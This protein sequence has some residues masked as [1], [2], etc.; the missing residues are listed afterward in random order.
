MRSCTTCGTRPSPTSTAGRRCSADARSDP[1]PRKTIPT[2]VAR[3]GDQASFIQQPGDPHD[4]AMLNVMPQDVPTGR[5]RTSTRPGSWASTTG[6]CNTGMTQAIGGI[7]ASGVMATNVVNVTRTR[8]RRRSVRRS[9][10]R[11]RA[12]CWTRRLGAVSP[13][14]TPGHGLYQPYDGLW[15]GH[16]ADKVCWHPYLGTCWV[17]PRSRDTTT[18]SRPGTRSSSGSRGSPRRPRASRTQGYAVDAEPV[19]PR[20]GRFAELSRISNTSITSWRTRLPF[21]AVVSTCTSS[22]QPDHRPLAGTH[23]LVKK[24]S[25]SPSPVG[26]AV[27]AGHGHPSVAGPGG[28]TTAETPPRWRT[29]GTTSHA[30]SPT[31]RLHERRGTRRPSG[32]RGH[33]DPQTSGAPGDQE[34]GRRI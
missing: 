8:G 3:V 17:S 22:T 21:V 6:L 23:R 31:D 2:P 10:S 29:G 15:G 27:C 30:S 5:Q 11:A 34:R 19:T 24:S 28:Q 26:P 20:P 13:S 12:W 25:C 7:P 32:R 14:A 33:P 4:R 16:D 1:M 9:S 18:P